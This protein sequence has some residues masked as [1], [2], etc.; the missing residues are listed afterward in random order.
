M[1]IKI[2]ND[3]P[4]TRTLQS[5]GVDVMS[6][7]EAARQDI[8]PL[9]IALLNLMPKKIETETQISRLIGATPLQVEMTLVSPSTYIPTNTPQEHMLAFYQPFDAIREERFDGLIITGAP[10]EELPFEEVKYWDELRRILDW[11]HANVHS[12]LNI[13]WGGQ[14]ALFHNHGVPKHML[15]GKLSG[16]YEHRVMKRTSPMVRGFNDALPVPV[17]R[18]TETRAIDVE[19]HNALSILLESDEAGVCLV[20]D[21]QYNAYY[22]FNHLEYDTRTLYNEYVRDLE[23]RP[24][25]VKVPEYYFPMNDPSKTPHNSWRA[26]GHLLMGNWINRI[27]QTTPFHLKDIGRERD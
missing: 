15:P 7:D 2:P 4:A 23:A 14:A 21:L 6:E 25:T 17:S 5:E 3:L 18:Y 10:V 19:K 16:V 1:P 13:C 22:M 20:E 27:Y 26:H 12:T 9:H 8:R 24:D 11:S